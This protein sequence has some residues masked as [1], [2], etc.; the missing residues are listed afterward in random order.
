MLHSLDIVLLKLPHMYVHSHRNFDYSF[1]SHFIVH[2][3]YA[4]AGRTTLSKKNM[5]L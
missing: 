5:T 3:T 2:G 4:R 1:F